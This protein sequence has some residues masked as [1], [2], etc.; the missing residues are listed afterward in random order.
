VIRQKIKSSNALAV[1]LK[2]NRAKS[3]RVVFT[4]G[5]FDILHIGH[6]KYLESAKKLGDIL[7]VGVNSDT[8]VRVI[9]GPGRPINSQD[10]RLGL[11]AALESVDYVTLF[12]QK[13]PEGLIRKLRPDILV[14]GADWN[15]KEIAGGDFVKSSGGRVVRIPLVKGHSTTALIKHITASREA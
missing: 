2:R 8:S 15:T 1:I 10:E 3:K 11:I 5:C 6:A 4:N 13:T 12:S 14:K 9:K 7:V